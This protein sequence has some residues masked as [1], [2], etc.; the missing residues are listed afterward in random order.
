MPAARNTMFI[1]TR[2]K[3]ALETLGNHNPMLIL[4]SKFYYRSY[5]YIQFNQG[6]P[7]QPIQD[8]IYTQLFMNSLNMRAKCRGMFL[9]VYRG[10]QMSPSHRICPPVTIFLPP[11]KSCPFLFTHL[12]AKGGREGKLIIYSW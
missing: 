10:G 2:I 3:T 12:Q 9:T 5:F 7:V 6:F 11:E 4:L 8:S 1:Y